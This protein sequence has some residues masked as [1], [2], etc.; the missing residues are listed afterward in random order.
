MPDAHQTTDR[1]PDTHISRRSLL[2][3]SALS[4][5]GIALTGS[6]EGLFGTEAA[7]A[8]SPGTAG[9]GPLVPDPAGILSLPA[10]FSYTIVAQT[11]VT[12]LESG[13]PT[14]ADPDGTA[15]F[16]RHAAD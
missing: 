10:G 16:V 13:E 8:K 7:S 15:S 6:V 4:C 5:I 3:R 12:T 2:N 9:Y 11:G 14:P 1:E